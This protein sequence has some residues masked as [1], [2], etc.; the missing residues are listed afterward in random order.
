[1]TKSSA[2]K[3]PRRPMT[4]VLSSV[5]NLLS[6]KSEDILRPFE[7]VG[8]MMT[9]HFSCHFVCVVTKATTTSIS[10]ETST[11]AGLFLIPDKSVKGKGTKTISPFV[12]HTFL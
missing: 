4:K 3:L 10:L 6:L 8:S 7:M 11:T 12:I 1:M 9:S 5:A 2:D